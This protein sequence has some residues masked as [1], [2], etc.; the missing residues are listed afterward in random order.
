MIVGA[1]RRPRTSVPLDGSAAAADR[2]LEISTL[3]EVAAYGPL[4]R[5]LVDDFVRHGLY[6]AAV[7]LHDDVGDLSIHGVTGIQ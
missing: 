4:L 7:R 1:A 5:N 3:A 6:L 2:P